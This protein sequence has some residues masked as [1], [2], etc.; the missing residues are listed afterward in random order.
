MRGPCFITVTS[1]SGEHVLAHIEL[2]G[3]SERADMVLV[4]VCSILDSDGTFPG[5]QASYMCLKNEDGIMLDP[6][7]VIYIGQTVRLHSNKESHSVIESHAVFVEFK[8]KEYIVCVS[9]PKDGV[10]IFLTI[11]KSLNLNTDHHVLEMIDGTLSLNVLNKRQKLTDERYCFLTMPDGVTEKRVLFK[12]NVI[13]ANKLLRLICKKIGL[14][15]D[16]YMFEED[17]TVV[18]ADDRLKMI[19]R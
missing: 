1:E 13:G 5:I 18:F 11:C 19:K 4:Q 10:L 9:D 16:E 3:K 12:W 17:V 14:N 2:T 6:S 15:P 8:D 7:A